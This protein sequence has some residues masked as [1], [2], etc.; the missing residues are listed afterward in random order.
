MSPNFLLLE[1]STTVEA[2]L[3]AIRHSAIP[4]EALS[5]VYVADTDGRLAGEVSVVR[6]LKAGSTARL[7]D[8][9]SGDPVTLRVDADRH[10]I[11]RKMTDFDLSATPVVDGDHRM[12]GLITV[13]DVLEM[14]LPTGWRRDFGMT[15]ADA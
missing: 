15:S 13:D 5:T 12:I 14:L 7:A 10:E 3:Q 6:L 4:P 8:V 9:I 2:A 11:Q 1:E